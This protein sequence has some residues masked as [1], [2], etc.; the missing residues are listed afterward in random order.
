MGRSARTKPA[1]LAE[2]LTRIRLALDLSQDQMVEWI[3]LD[4]VPG[5]QYVSGYELG[6]REPTLTVL[7]RISR[8]ARVPLENMIDDELDVVVPPEVIR[9][10]RGKV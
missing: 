10:A 3:D 5:R 2:K 4:E 6:T 8:L 9:A 1:R 7:L